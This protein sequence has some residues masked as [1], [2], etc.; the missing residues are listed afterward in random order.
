MVE[1]GGVEV[2]GPR[3]NR[4]GACR[5]RWGCP[6][7]ARIQNHVQRLTAGQRDRVGVVVH[8]VSSLIPQQFGVVA[9]HMHGDPQRGQR[10]ILRDVKIGDA[11]E[12]LLAGSHGDDRWQRL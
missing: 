11:E 2:I 9:D 1:V 4:G 8:V 3:R 6:R 10:L 5:S 7:R 12:G